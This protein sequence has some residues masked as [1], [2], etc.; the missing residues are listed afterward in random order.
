MKTRLWMLFTV[1]CSCLYA[2]PTITV[3]LS[4]DTIAI[5]ELVEV[6]YTIE[7]GQGK[8]DMPDM[9]DLPVVSGPNSSSSFIYQNGEMRSSQSYSFKLRPRAPGIVQIPA[10]GYVEKDERIEIDPVQVVVLGDGLMP[11]PAVPE[12][13]AAKSRAAR[14]KRK[15]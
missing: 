13:P 12:S 6:T 15:F 2:Q 5:G 14:E 1:A 4:A 3:K 7:N 8:F 10:A 11:L 9:M